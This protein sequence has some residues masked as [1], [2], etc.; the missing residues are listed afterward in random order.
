[1]A[2]PGLNLT[3][4][5]IPTPH[6][7][8][9]VLD[10]GSPATGSSLP[11]LLLL[12]GNSSSSQIFTPLL[13]LSA[14][15]PT[16]SLHRT[17][18]LDLPGHGASTDAPDPEASYT[19]PAYAAC[20]A[21][22]LDAL[23]ATDVVALG[24]SLGGHNAIELLA[25][26]GPTNRVRG[27]MLTGTPPALGLDQVKRGFGVRDPAPGEPDDDHM[28][29]AAA[30]TWTEHDCDTFPF[31]AARGPREPWIREAAARTDGRARRIMFEAFEGGRGADQV[32]VVEESDVPVAVVNGGDEP[33]V[34]LDYLD[35]IKYKNL[36]EGK[37]YR[38]PGQG[39]APFWEQPETFLPY[40]ERFVKHCSGGEV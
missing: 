17:L 16:L 23:H 20:A 33:F 37:C 30:E 29:L 38:L 10:T 24:W 11:T 39:H 36:W 9:S 21:A 26:L 1:M 15:S 3:T 13:R 31:E 32:G 28:N 7:T 35:G 18:A 2:T 40:W 12:H 6:G 8:I 27:I 5:R 34:N 4:H 19:Q 25:Q 22:V 14:A